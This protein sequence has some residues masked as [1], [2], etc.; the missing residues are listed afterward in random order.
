MPAS[1]DSA[2][3]AVGSLRAWLDDAQAEHGDGPAEVA[4]GLLQWA[5]NLPDDA[6]GAAAIHLAEHVWLAHLVN[7]ANPADVRGL[8][9]FIAA[10]PPELAQAEATAPSLARASWALAMVQGQSAA[11][12]ALPDVS[13]WRALQ[14]VVLAW[15]RAQGLEG[16][17][18]HGLRLRLGDGRIHVAFEARLGDRQ[19]QA[20]A[21]LRLEP[22]S[23]G[24][25]NMRQ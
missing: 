23:Q 1:P 22:S 13:R 18:L 12:A 20:T 17:G 24:E 11:A 4:A 15:V 25:V 19:A 2:A 5:P 14:N 16:F 8:Q 10:L 9:A 21:R 7:P 6:L 3:L